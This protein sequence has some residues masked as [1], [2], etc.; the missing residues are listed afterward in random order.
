MKKTILLAAAMLPVAL[1]AQNDQYEIV[2]RKQSW[3]KLSR[4]YRQHL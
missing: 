3:R 4:E 2:S 1:F